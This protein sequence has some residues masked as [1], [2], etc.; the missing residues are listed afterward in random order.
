LNEKGLLKATPGNVIDYDIMEEDI[1]DICKLYEVEEIGYDPHNAIRTIIK[2]QEE[3]LVCAE[4]RQN[5][6]MLS[7]PTKEIQK[8]VMSKKDEIA[9]DGHEVMRWNV[10]NTEIITDKNENIRPIKGPKTERIDGM[11]ALINAMA[12]AML[13]VDTKSVYE[14]RGV[15]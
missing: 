3:G 6:T 7:D 14:E 12:R 4:V 9:H 8:L 10:G 11:V 5:F 1:L 15:R 2:F 13:H